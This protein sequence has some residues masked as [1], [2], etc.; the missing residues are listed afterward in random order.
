MDNN[1]TI[2]ENSVKYH[3]KGN[4]EGMSMKK[5]FFILYC[6]FSVTLSFAYDFEVD[7]YRF[8]VLTSTT[9]EFAGVSPNHKGEVYIPEFVTFSGKQLTVSTI[10][11][12]AFEEYKAAFLRIPQHINYIKNA[13]FYKAQIDSLHFDNSE[14]SIS[15]QNTINRSPAMASSQLGSVYIGRQINRTDYNSNADGPFIWSSV[16]RVYIGQTCSFCQ[17]LFS[18]C[19][20]LEQ[21]VVKEGFYITSIDC[22]CF[23]YCSKLKYIDLK[24][25]LTS[26]SS[27]AF[28]NCTSLDSIYIP[29]TV[30]YI[31]SY[32][33]SNDINIK[34]VVSASD[35]PNA[36]GVEAFPG[37]VYLTATLSVPIGAKTKYEKTTGWKEFQNIAEINK[38]PALQQCEMPL[39]NYS[40]GKILLK[41][42]TPGATY[43]YTLSA[44][45]I[46]NNNINTNGIINLK[47]KYDIFAYATAEGYKQ[48]NT[49]TATL[50]WL[51]ANLE[52]DNIK[53]A[54]TRGIVVSSNNGIISISGLDNNEKVSFY[55]TDGIT[56]GSQKAID[57]CVN[58]AVGTAEKFII[59]RIGNN[60]L[61]VTN[62]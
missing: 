44:P 22:E 6:M 52:T 35:S 34:R 9:A 54:Q 31:S 33:F 48:S 49:V 24:E 3:T 36:I 10:V 30:T 58:Y 26:I 37:I 12:Y 23:N 7:G 40:N 21:V 42:S 27:S 8:T 62:Q 25:G 32:A 39:I 47:G 4:P 61:K 57:G 45:D 16:K 19:N 28:N 53:Q 59:V 60:S 41:C 46:A 17:E 38:E 14:K 51:N 55:S 18:G 13:A 2:V 50:Y 20:N 56:L 15:L 29:S 43:Y 5:L 1:K 11:E